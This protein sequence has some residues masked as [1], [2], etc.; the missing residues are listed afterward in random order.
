MSAAAIDTG[1]R[2]RRGWGGI[3]WSSLV[4]ALMAFFLLNVLGV[5]ASV[6]VNSFATRWFGTWLPPGFTTR[7]YASAWD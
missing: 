3:L 2:P 4:A 1:T 5:I 6:L 7:W